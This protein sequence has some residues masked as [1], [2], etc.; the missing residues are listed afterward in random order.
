M[1][2]SSIL[3]SIL[4]SVLAVSNIFAEDVVE[5]PPEITNSHLSCRKAKNES[6]NPNLANPAAD[7]I[8][9]LQQQD[10]TLKK[11]TINLKNVELCVPSTKKL[12]TIAGTPGFP[13]ELKNVDPQVVK[14]DFLCYIMKCKGNGAP[15]YQDV[16][17]QFGKKR[18]RFTGKKFRVCVPAWKLTYAENEDELKP[19]IIEDD[20]IF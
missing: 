5:R 3:L 10:Y 19:I 6:Y 12:Y 16:G 8:A 17:D 1:I 9:N 4:C 18:I 2:S 20:I 7:F 11:C 15:E 14:N 13:A